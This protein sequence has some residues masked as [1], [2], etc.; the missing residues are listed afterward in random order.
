MMHDSSAICWGQALSSCAAE[1]KLQEADTTHHSCRI[2]SEQ[3]E[4]VHRKR[5]R[6]TSST[7]RS[8]QAA[9][10]FQ[11]DSAYLLRISAR[12]CTPGKV[13]LGRIQRPADFTLGACA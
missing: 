1:S 9:S 8:M 10:M 2:H 7:S 12:S 11:P 6:L 4:D 3:Q 5:L 13:L